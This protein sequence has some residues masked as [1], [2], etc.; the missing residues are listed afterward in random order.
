M[1]IEIFWLYIQGKSDSKY[2][3]SSWQ[4]RRNSKT[5]K[6]NQHTSAWR[7]LSNKNPSP[8]GL[9][10]ESTRQRES[11]GKRWK[12]EWDLL[13]NWEIKKDVVITCGLSEIS[14]RALTKGLRGLRPDGPAVR[15]SPLF[16]FHITPEFANYILNFVLFL[17]FKKKK[18]LCYFILVKKYF[19]SYTFN[20]IIVFKFWF[21]M[22]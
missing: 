9:A 8:Q 10:S 11:G 21:V 18:H 2:S 4:Q 7:T 1:E 5:N 13:V 16:T 14:W 3:I 20:K 15:K 17:L 19:W 6:I 12:I 22:I